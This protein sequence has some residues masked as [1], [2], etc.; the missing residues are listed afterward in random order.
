MPKDGSYK[1][2]KVSLGGKFDRR[3]RICRFEGF[4][5][6]ADTTM[7]DVPVSDTSS[8]SVGKKFP[9]SFSLHIM[10]LTESLLFGR[11]EEAQWLYVVLQRTP[12]QDQGREP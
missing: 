5:R 7:E 2:T 12:S 1:P 9:H 4:F 8:M 3:R 11:Q 6:V 10:I